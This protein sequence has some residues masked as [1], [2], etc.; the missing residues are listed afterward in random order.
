MAV[1]STENKTTGII[2]NSSPIQNRQVFTP[3]T[4]FIMPSSDNGSVSEKK[5]HKPRLMMTKMVL[6]NF[7]SY[8]GVVEIGPFHKSFSSI[9]GP[10]GSGKSNVI[11]A[12]LFVFGF[13]AKKMRQE[14]LGQLVHNSQKFSDLDFCKVEIHFQRIIDIDEFRYSVI[15][16]SSFIVSRI[17]EKGDK[18]DKSSYKIRD[19]SSNFKDRSSSYTEVTEMMKGFGVD[20]DHKRFLILQGEVELIAQMKPKAANE[21]DDGLLEY[22]E[23]IIGTTHFKQIIEES[24]IKLEQ[25][26]EERA[27]KLD[28]VKLLEKDKNAL[29][30]KKEDAVKYVEIQNERA[31]ALN[32]LCQLERVEIEVKQR[33][34]NQ[35]TI[36]LTERMRGILSQRDEA[37]TKIKAFEKEL[38][39]LNKELEDTNKSVS[40]VDAELQKYDREEI[41]LEE[42]KKHLKKK[43]EKLEKNL[44]Q[45]SLKLNE[46]ETWLGHFDSDLNKINKEIDTLSK[47]LIVEEAELDSIR[48]SLQGKTV[49]FQTQLEE[50][51]RELGPWIEKIDS[52]KAALD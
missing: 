31:R 33:S 42:K 40:K 9:V 38:K 12:L 22:L 51:Q 39:N 46:N 43:K 41:E 44:Q 14:K 30:N 35:K 1:E 52:E 15:P 23:D 47:R 28:R 29:E 32:K 48:A 20:L 21:N 10:N 36:E 3:P 11:D 7:K 13:K 49:V 34:S 2:S 6:E 50:K 24:G 17:V 19:K 4:K 5:Q 8:A 26:N 37:E 18:T 25:L 45:D 27:N 16:D